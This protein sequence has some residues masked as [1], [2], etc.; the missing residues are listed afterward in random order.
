V[1]LAGCVAAAATLVPITAWV[2][3]IATRILC[4][5]LLVAFG[6]FIGMILESEDL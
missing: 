2:D 1:I 3:Q 6:V 5:I 4:A